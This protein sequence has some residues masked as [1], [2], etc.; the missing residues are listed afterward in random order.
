MWT[1]VPG[2]LKDFKFEPNSKLFFMPRQDY[3][4]GK[5]GSNLR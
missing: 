4:L 5:A 1:P 2:L 3:D